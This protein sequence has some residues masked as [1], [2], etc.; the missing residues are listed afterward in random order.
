MVIQLGHRAAD[1]ALNKGERKVLGSGCKRAARP[2]RWSAGT[3]AP[4]ASDCHKPE[5]DTTPSF[6]RWRE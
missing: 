2:A 6:T 4:P 5:K 3:P 1:N